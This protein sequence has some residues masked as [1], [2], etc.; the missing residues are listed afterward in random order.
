MKRN[1]E[2]ESVR[3]SFIEEHKRNRAIIESIFSKAEEYENKF[4]K[5][6]CAFNTEEILEFLKGYKATYINALQSRITH[7]KK[8]CLVCRASGIEEAN[9]GEWNKITSDMISS[10]VDTGRAL[11]KYFSP[12]QME[13]IIDSLINPVDRFVI[14]GFYEGLRGDAYEDIWDLYADDIDKETRTVNLSHDR[15]ARYGMNG[16]KKLQVSQKLID[17]ILA[18]LKTEEYVY[19]REGSV[20]TRSIEFNDTKGRVFRVAKTKISESEYENLIVEKQRVSTKFKAI[21]SILKMPELTIPAIVN[22]AVIAKIKELAEENGDSFE[23][24]VKSEA[25]VPVQVRYGLL[26]SDFTKL[27]EKY[28]IYLK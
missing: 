24:A 23:K 4:N 27:L 2:I 13:K 22:S 7:I 9:N 5:D 15:L 14:R 18:S 6:L 16:N 28:S 26:K 3:L 21:K 10:C 11:E 19:T 20:G 17:D 8:Y 25:F 1:E 12:E